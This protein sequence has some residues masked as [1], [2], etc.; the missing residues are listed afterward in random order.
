MSPLV[1]H[2]KVTIPP[3][4]PP[5]PPPSTPPPPHT[6]PALICYRR[7]IS[8]YIHYERIFYFP[9]K[10][11]NVGLLCN[12]GCGPDCDQVRRTCLGSYEESEKF[13]YGFLSIFCNCFLF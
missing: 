8:E 4:P 3:P 12:L 9:I 10:V 1:D 2:D 11:P 6:L 13:Y 5:P 7:I